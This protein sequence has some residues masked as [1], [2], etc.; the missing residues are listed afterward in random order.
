MPAEVNEG[1]VLPDIVI[2]GG[3]IGSFGGRYAEVDPVAA[4]LGD[5]VHRGDRRRAV[6]SQELFYVVDDAL[7]EK[8]V[9]R[10]NRVF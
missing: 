1:P 6:G 4:R 2:I 3:D 9:G 5:L 7:H 10:K 8:I